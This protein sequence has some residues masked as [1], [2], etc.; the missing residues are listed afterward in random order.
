MLGNFIARAVADDCIPPVYVFGNVDRGSFNKLAQQAIKRAESLLSLKTTMVHLDNVWGSA[1][2]MRPVKTITKRMA[3]LLK[4]FVDSRDVCEAQ[5]CLRELEVPHYHHEL[6]Y[7]AIVMAVEAVHGT[8]AEAMCQLL[9]ALDEACLVTP[10]TMEQGFQRVY[11]DMTDIVLDVPLAYIMLDRFVDRCHARGILTEKIVAKM[12]SRLV[13]CG[14]YI[15][16]AFQM[17]GAPH[18]TCITVESSIFIYSRSHNP[19]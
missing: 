18:A 1:G 2:P 6:V 10:A 15:V 14:V 19:N 8:V 13:V 16:M 9:A 3:A 12:P 5:H 4:E 11:D 17:I 7:E